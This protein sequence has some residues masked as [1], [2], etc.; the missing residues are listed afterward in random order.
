MLP[1]KQQSIYGKNVTKPASSLRFYLLTLL[2]SCVIALLVAEVV[3]RSLSYS[4]GTGIGRAHERWTEQYWRPVNEMGIRDFSVAARL[5]LAQPKLYFLGDSFTA[6]HGVAFE[7]TFYFRTAERLSHAYN[8]FNLSLNGAST[9]S[10]LQTLYQFNTATGSQARI[11]VHQYFLNDID[12]YIHRP[13]WTPPPLLA[14]LGRYLASAEFLLAYRFNEEWGNRYAQALEAAYLDAN[15]MD[16]HETN[17][18]LLHE[19]IRQQGGRV[20]FMIFPALSPDSRFERSLGAVDRIRDI[21]RKHCRPGDLY[22]DIPALARTLGE[23]DRIVNFMDP[24]PSARL[25]ALV[26]GQ[27]QRAIAHIDRGEPLGEYQQACQ[28]DIGS[29]TETEIPPG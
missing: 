19:Y 14:F 28:P 16:K 8:L 20:V 17:L 1:E 25:H 10:Q 13:E 29:V 22:I 15:T 9:R 5:P 6:G 23:S 26:A 3:L 2:L 11:V 24:H 7:E 4:V 12:D 27:V 18:R 21:Y